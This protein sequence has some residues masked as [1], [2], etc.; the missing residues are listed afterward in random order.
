MESAFAVELS[1][2]RVPFRTD[3]LVLHCRFKGVIVVCF[4]SNS[5]N[6]AIAIVVDDSRDLGCTADRFVCGESVNQMS[7]KK[8]Y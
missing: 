4:G 6:F 5:T 2:L 1:K 8:S 3:P 7:K